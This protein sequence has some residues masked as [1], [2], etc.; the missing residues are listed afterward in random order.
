MGSILGKKEE[1]KNE[2]KS[3]E[4][5]NQYFFTYL[6]TANIKTYSENQELD[7]SVNE[8]FL[9][10]GTKNETID[11]IIAEGF[12]ERFAEEAGMYGPGIYFAENSSKANQYVSC[13]NCDGGA[14][15]KGEKME[16]RCQ[17]EI[18][19]RIILARVC[20]GTPFLSKD[21]SHWRNSKEERNDKTKIGYSPFP[22]TGCELCSNSGSCY[23]DSVYAED[24]TRGG[25]FLRMREF[26]VYD[27]R[28][29]YPEF[30]I[31]YKRKKV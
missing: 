28:Q 17:G 23:H 14:I 3:T 7:K 12:D 1:L 8:F 25:D 10:H 19:Y 15:K 31:H 27:K 18:E 30:I 16:C 2:M 5:H 26:I 11:K 29:T 13:P 6:S 21:Y 20:L 4:V 9:F 22:K 24:K